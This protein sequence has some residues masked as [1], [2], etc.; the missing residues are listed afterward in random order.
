MNLA[1]STNSVRQ[2]NNDYCAACGGNGQLL[3]CDG[4]P[5]SFHFS[6][7][8]P[9][10]DPKVPPE[11]EWYCPRCMARRNRGPAH[12]SGILGRI[13][14]RIEDINPKAFAL[15]FDIREYF[16]GV[17]TG[18][19]GEYE[20]VGIPR[21]QN[22]VAK[23]NR[24]GFIDEPN[25]K[26]LRDSKGNLIT[27]YHCQLTSD[28]R[29]IIPCDYCPARW[30][31]DCLDPPLAVP[32]RR[33][34]DNPNS[35]W[36][37]PLHVENDLAAMDRADT[38]SPGDLGRIPRLRKPRNAIPYDVSLSRG[39]RNNGLIEIELIKD[40]EPDVKEVEMMGTV[41]RLPEKGIRLDF[42]DRVKR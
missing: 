41:Y 14:N 33:R 24:A 31:L 42:I 39:F 2:E 16:E 8:D 4:C 19:E 23:M 17:K 18:D 25:Y 28:G 13:I 35:T 21:T 5:N 10:M 32:P 26:E 20:E 15:P 27:C 22:N 9:P 29:D 37:C 1:T 34:K 30:H 36:R 3:C 12:T 6:C 7:L 40:E 38:A 11:G